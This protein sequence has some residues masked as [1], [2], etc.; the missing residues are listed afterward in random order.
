MTISLHSDCLI[1]AVAG[2]SASGKSLIANT[3]FDELKEE[4]GEAK[5]AIISEDSYYRDQSHLEMSERI[6]TN[7][8]H[9]DSL[10]HKLLRDH[11]AALI[12]GK[13]A[14]IPQYCYSTHNRLTETTHLSPKKVIILEGILLLTSPEL[15]KQF[16]MSIFMDAPL[17]I[18]LLRRLTRDVAERGRTMESVLKQYQE[19]VRPMFVKYIKPS[20]YHADLIIPRGGKN[21]IAIDVLKAKIV[22]MLKS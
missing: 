13:S 10:E 22:D 17:D 12:S 19:T 6:K 15:R 5:I 16:H 20:K 9:P 1:I 21:R 18:C 4:L 7:Y 14:D 2:A 3:V 11:L 8:D